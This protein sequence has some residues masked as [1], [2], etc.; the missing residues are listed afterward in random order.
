MAS[1]RY[2]KLFDLLARRGYKKTDLM[3]EVGLSSVTVAKLSKGESVTTDTILRICERFDV[4]PGDIME[5]V[6]D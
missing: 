1:I 6:P 4:Q 5:Y 3:K 2:Y